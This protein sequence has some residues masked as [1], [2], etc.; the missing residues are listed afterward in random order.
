[1][2]WLHFSA[3]LENPRVAAHMTAPRQRSHMAFFTAKEADVTEE[4]EA[5]STQCWGKTRGE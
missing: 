2:F 3:V 4:R 1:M 5:T